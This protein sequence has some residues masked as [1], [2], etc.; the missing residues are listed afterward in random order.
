MAQAK[1]QEWAGQVS[2]TANPAS[3]DREGWDFFLQFPLSQASESIPLDLRPSRIEC[4]VQVKGLGLSHSKKP[5]K[6]RRKSI[7]LSNWE[8]LVKSPLPAFFLIVDYGSSNDPRNAYLIHVDQKWISSVLERLRKVPTEGKDRVNKQTLDLVWSEVNRIVSLDGQGLK[9]AIEKCI[10][11]DFDGYVANKQKLRSEVGIDAPIVLHITS[12]R[13]RNNDDLFNQLIDFA[14]GLRDSI[15]VSQLIVEKQV[16]FGI[17]AERSE[18]GA[19][20]LAITDRS[21][22]AKPVKV[23]IS[24]H[25]QT[26]T[27]IFP[28]TLHTPEYLFPG[29]GVPEKL[30]KVRIE[31]EIG[32]IVISTGLGTMEVRSFGIRA[33]NEPRK[34]GELANLWR[35]VL[36]FAH[37]STNGCSLD[38]SDDHNT[39][40]RFDLPHDVQFTQDYLSIAQVVDDAWFCAKIFDIAPDREVVLSE[41]LRNHSIFSETRAIYDANL[42]IAAITSGV[43]SD[44]SLSEDKEY[45]LV[46]ARKL[47]LAQRV[48]YMV[49]GY[50]GYLILQTGRD[51]TTIEM[52]HPRQVYLEHRV[53]LN[54]DD[55]AFEQFR[56]NAEAKLESKGFELIIA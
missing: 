49:V 12:E 42:P 4:L 53:V 44:A 8:K 13:F 29:G 17:P 3:Q 6:R 30:R 48:V 34:L 39:P 46:I 35:A 10:G 51:E 9:S 19:G 1:L 21:K 45:A 32:D 43:N 18:G 28:S 14:I 50:A 24:N 2:I 47:P 15:P 31:T 16:R 56:K 22:T 5:V 38:I 41:L 55:L 36:I 33:N 20:V 27:A 11:N 7:E 26:Q 52:R 37:A 40:V 23:T 25:S 54:V